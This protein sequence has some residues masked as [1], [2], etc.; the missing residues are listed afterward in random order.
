MLLR[1]NAAF[2]ETTSEGVER[3]EQLC[4][5]ALERDPNSAM[6]Y[7]LLSNAQFQMFVS[8]YRRGT[9]E[10]W[11]QMLD[12]A[13]KATR[14]DPN[15]ASILA[16]YAGTLAHMAGYD[17]AL[18]LSDRAVALNPS[19][20]NVYEGRGRALFFNSRY[21]DAIK[22]IE[23]FLKLS[24]SDPLY[25]TAATVLGY[26][27]FCLR[28]YEAALSWAKEAL[29]FAPH[30]TQ[31]QG[32]QAATLAQLGR[33][34]EA[35]AAIARFLDSVPTATANRVASNFRLRNQD[36]VAHYREGLIKAGLPAE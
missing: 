25:Y 15:D 28:N 7:R 2:H 6:A 10:A 22:A 4:R 32:L 27:Q 12:F 26:A 29:R 34:D 24:P 9:T 14:L 31:T 21:E 5:Q 13:E 18:K 16:Y 23:R 20:A 8:G 35:Q 1:A 33:T 11:R 17:Q 36:D 19:I 30:F 3:A